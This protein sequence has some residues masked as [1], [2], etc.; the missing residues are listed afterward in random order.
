QAAGNVSTVY[1]R[2]LGELARTPRLGRW[3][4]TRVARIGAGRAVAR[5]RPRPA[6]RYQPPARAADV[7][8]ALRG[9]RGSGYRRRK[10]VLPARGQKW[11]GPDHVGLSLSS[12]AGEWA[13]CSA[14]DPARL[15]ARHR[16]RVAADL[17]PRGCARARPEWGGCA[18]RD[19]KPSGTTGSVGS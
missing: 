15:A 10:P 4:L 7:R 18:P 6:R 9:K 5:R 2:H 8:V 3:L 12:D 1:S 11:A 13:L 19:S 14:R 16:K 17:R